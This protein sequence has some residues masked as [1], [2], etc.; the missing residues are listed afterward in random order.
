MSSYPSSYTKER[1]SIRLNYDK[2]GKFRL[3]IDAH[4]LDE[5]ERKGGF[6][7]MERHHA[8]FIKTLK[9]AKAKYTEWKQVAIDNN[10]SDYTKLMDFDINLFGYFHYANRWHVDAN[11]E[12]SIVFTVVPGNPSTHKYLLLIET[13]KLIS[14]ED[15]KIESDG[16]LLVFRSV[17]GISEFINT[18]SLES[19]KSFQNKPSTDDLFK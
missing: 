9:K 17:S 6:Y 15:E 2:H 16:F 18:I 4:C 1:F 3:W 8:E 5:P 12:P 19:I 13:N 11:P 10:I 14:Y 7:V